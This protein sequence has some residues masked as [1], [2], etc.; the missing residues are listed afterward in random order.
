[1]KPAPPIIYVG[2]NYDEILQKYTDS[3]KFY[4][5]ANGVPLFLLSSE[6]EKERNRFFFPH[7]EKFS[8]RFELLNKLSVEELHLLNHII[9]SNKNSNKQEKENSIYIL[10]EINRLLK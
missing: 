1:M 2:Q 6:V 4:I 5:K 9:I 8:F 3:L 10:K 7:T